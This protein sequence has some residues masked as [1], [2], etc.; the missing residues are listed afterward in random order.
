[1][2]FTKNIRFLSF[3][4]KSLF[5]KDQKINLRGKA[6]SNKQRKNIPN[7]IT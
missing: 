1:M 2:E 4:Q 7:S 6:A 3:K 5:I